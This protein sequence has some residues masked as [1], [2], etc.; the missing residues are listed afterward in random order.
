MSQL[1][2]RPFKIHQIRSQKASKPLRHAKF[3]FTGPVHSVALA[4]SLLFSFT[5]F[6]MSGLPQG[7]STFV[8]AVLNTRL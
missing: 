3:I 8:L 4:L 1:I 5:L 2:E 7:M 6:S